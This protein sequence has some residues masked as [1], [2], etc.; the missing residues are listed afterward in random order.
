MCGYHKADECPE[1]LNGFIGGGGGGGGGV[2][3]VKV[4]AKRA[5]VYLSI[6]YIILYTRRRVY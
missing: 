5:S 2:D 6:R 1:H 4:R 3:K